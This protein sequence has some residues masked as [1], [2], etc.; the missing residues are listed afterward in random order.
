MSIDPQ[1]GKEVTGAAK[2]RKKHEKNEA[3][4]ASRSRNRED[5]GKWA[6]EFKE[7]GTPDLE[8]PGTDL[9]YTRKLQLI[10]LRQMATTPFPTLA[11]MECW[12]RINEMSKSV[13]MTSNRAQLEA[14]VKKLG[15]ALKAQTVQAGAITI[16][17]GHTVKKPSTA[18]G[19]SPPGPRAIPP[20]ALPEDPPPT[21]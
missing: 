21:D 6:D 9:D 4:V 3:Q 17:P 8:N 2:I 19:M 1:T 16:V 12:R 11:Q 7:A 5:D 10:C 13:G 14:S 20:D 15:K 18:R